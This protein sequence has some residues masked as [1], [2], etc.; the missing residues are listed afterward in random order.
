[1]LG[2]S[3]QGECVRLLTGNEVGSIPTPPAIHMKKLYITVA[4][5]LLFVAPSCLS[6][7]QQEQS[8]AIKSEYIGT[9]QGCKVYKIKVNRMPPQLLWKDC[10]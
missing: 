6:K 5:V 7:E 8:N 2:D 1:M 9:T 4:I 3:I 10:E